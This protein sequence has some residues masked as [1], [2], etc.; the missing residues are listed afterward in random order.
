[1]PEIQAVNSYGHRPFEINLVFGQ[2]RHLRLLVEEEV[3]T[4]LGPVNPIVDTDIEGGLPIHPEDAVLDHGHLDDKG[5]L[6]YEEEVLS[7][8]QSVL[9]LVQDHLED[10]I[11]NIQKVY[12]LDGDGL[13]LLHVGIGGHGLQQAVIPH[14]SIH[15]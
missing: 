15:Q 9:R 8:V 10:Q 3:D 5:F 12:S 7:E 11:V 2:P 6:I 1:L 14:E 13:L 4:L